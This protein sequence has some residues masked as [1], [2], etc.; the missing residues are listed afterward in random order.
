MGGRGRDE[1]EGCERPNKHPYIFG[2]GLYEDRCGGPIHRIQVHRLKLP[3][4][5]VELPSEEAAA[6]EGGDD[7]EPRTLL[8]IDDGDVFVLALSWVW[9]WIMGVS[10]C[11]GYGC[12]CVC[13]FKVSG[14]MMGVGVC[15][16]KVSVGWWR[17]AAAD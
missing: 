12:W 5:E 8:R 13:V 1:G 15:V 4:G 10:V 11:G 3:V 14:G 2:P 16:F 6:G 9:V 7:A 17:A